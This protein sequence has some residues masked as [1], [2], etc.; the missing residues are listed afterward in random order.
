MGIGLSAV[1]TDRQLPLYPPEVDQRRIGV[2]HLKALPGLLAG[3]TYLR[4]SKLGLEDVPLF[5]VCLGFP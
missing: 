3:P 1:R 4:K 2:I 5:L